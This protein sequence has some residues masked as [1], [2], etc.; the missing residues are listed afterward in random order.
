MTNTRIRDTK[1]AGAKYPINFTQPEKLF[2]LSLH[3]NGMQDVNGM[4]F[5]HIGNNSFLDIDKYLMKI[6]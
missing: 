2:V 1:A 4:N 5:N 3:L 6:T